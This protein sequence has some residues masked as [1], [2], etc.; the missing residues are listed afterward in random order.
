MEGGNL[1]KVF[2]ATLVT[3]E[4]LEKVDL[5]EVKLRTIISEEDYLSYKDFLNYRQR[6]HKCPQMALVNF[7]F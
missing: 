1:N 7:L 2:Q 3:V 5:S 4:V 6:N